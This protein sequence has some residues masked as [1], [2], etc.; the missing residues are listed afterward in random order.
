MERKQNRLTK[1]PGLDY[2]IRYFSREVA[3]GAKLSRGTPHKFCIILTLNLP[4]GKPRQR[5]KDEVTQKAENGRDEVQVHGS[6]TANS[7]WIQP[8]PQVR[9]RSAFE[10]EG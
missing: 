1:C 6:I 4:E 9:D 10:P 7:V 5:R 8:V 3:L 2:I